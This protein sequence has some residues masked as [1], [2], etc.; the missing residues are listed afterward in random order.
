M[1]EALPLCH[2][3]AFIFC[4]GNIHQGGHGQIEY[5]EFIGNQ[6]MRGWCHFSAITLCNFSL[7]QN[8]NKLSQHLQNPFKMS[9]NSAD[10]KNIPS[11]TRYKRFLNHSPS[12]NSSRLPSLFWF[13]NR[14]NFEKRFFFFF[15][16]FAFD[17]WNIFHP[18]GSKSLLG[19]WTYLQ[20]N[21]KC[22]FF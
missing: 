1:A 22:S 18:D 15:F 6:S 3:A 13:G 21:C 8:A 5:W 14:C 16:F 17:R 7:L 9:F 12:C 4:G 10:G 2:Y 11:V 20:N 19:V